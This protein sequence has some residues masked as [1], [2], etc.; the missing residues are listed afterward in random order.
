MRTPEILHFRLT[1]SSQ[2]GKIRHHLYRLNCIRK[3]EI[4][5]QGDFL[6]EIQIDKIEWLKL[7]KQFP[8]LAEK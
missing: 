4:S 2:E 8:K 6:L 7:I 5:E 1:L 3:E